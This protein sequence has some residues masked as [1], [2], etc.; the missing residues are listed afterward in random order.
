MNVEIKEEMVKCRMMTPPAYRVL[1]ECQNCEHNSGTKEVRPAQNGI[2]AFYSIMCAIPTI[3]LVEKL[4]A[5]QRNI[6]QEVK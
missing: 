6:I 2:P 4:I 3:V 5:A 1:K